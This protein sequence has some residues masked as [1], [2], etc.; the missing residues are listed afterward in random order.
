[1]AEIAK[2]TTSRSSGALT[3]FKFEESYLTG[4]LSLKNAS[5][6]TKGI[7]KF[8]RFAWSQWNT[9]VYFTSSGTSLTGKLSRMLVDDLKSVIKN[10]GINDCLLKPEPLSLNTFKKRQ[11]IQDGSVNFSLN[12][13]IILCFY[14]VILLMR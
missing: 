6:F 2:T 12:L 14:K 4:G 11:N 10:K 13:L 5:E 7:V 8:Q 3:A 1:M 9:G